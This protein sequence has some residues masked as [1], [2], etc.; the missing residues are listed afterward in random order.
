MKS[1]AGTLPGMPF[2]IANARVAIHKLAGLLF[3]MCLPN[4]WYTSL[5]RHLCHLPFGIARFAKSCRWFV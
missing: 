1:R 2:V 4:V 3:T 5:T